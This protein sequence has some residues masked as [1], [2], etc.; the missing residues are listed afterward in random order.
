M[1]LTTIITL[2][3]LSLTSFGQSWTGKYQDYFGH[4]LT[5]N[6]DSTFKFDWRFDLIHDWSAGQWTVSGRTLKLEFN[7]I[8]DTLSR[9]DKVDSLVLSADEKSNRITGI[10]FA[11]T[12][13]QS[14]GQNR[15]RFQDLFTLR[16]N[17]LYLA[18]K[19]GR[20]IKSRHRGI[21][22]KKKWPTFYKKER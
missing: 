13:L 9:P 4:E 17:R 11:E 2:T 6:E 8:Y 22:T 20:P 14:G 12:G 18:D 10:E 7:I 16:V 21:W 15:D 5:L 3:L 19:N 1:R